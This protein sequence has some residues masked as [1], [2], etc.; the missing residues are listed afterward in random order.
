MKNKGFTLIELLAVIVILA[1]IA[2]IATPIILGIISDSKT[3]ADLRTVE[4]YAKAVEYAGVKY[5]YSHNGDEPANF[6][7]ISNL[8][9]YE[10]AT[11]SGSTVTYSGGRVTLAGCAITGGSTGYSY[12]AGKA[13]K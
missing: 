3:Q 1:V 5:M 9:Q 8:V 11:V 12:S 10:G 4:G 6:N 13:T 7:A 2:L